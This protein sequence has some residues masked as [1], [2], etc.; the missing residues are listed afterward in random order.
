[1]TILILEDSRFLPIS[2][3]WALVRAGYQVITAADGEEGLRL[4][5]E[6]RRDLVILDLMLPKLPGREV[7]RALR[8]RPETAE[9]PVMVVSSLPQSDDR[10]LMQERATSYFEKAGLMLDRGSGLVCANRW[11]SAFAVQS[12]FPLTICAR[13]HALHNFGQSSSFGMVAYEGFGCG[14]QSAA[15]HCERASKSR[16]TKSSLRAMAKKEVC[17]WQ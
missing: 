12:G 14:R 10:Q 17:A 15:S 13:T 9:I 1:M 6:Q 2:N 16:A 11:Q 4:A 5:R 7:L 3:E 8:S